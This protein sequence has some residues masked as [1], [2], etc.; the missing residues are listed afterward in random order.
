MDRVFADRGFF[1]SQGRK[2]AFLAIQG[3]DSKAGSLSTSPYF[4]G[5]KTGAHDSFEPL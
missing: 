1:R 2:S 3:N 5:I 4:L